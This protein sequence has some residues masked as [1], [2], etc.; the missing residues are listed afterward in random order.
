MARDWNKAVKTDQETFLLPKGKMLWPSIFEKSNIKGE[1]DPEKA[2][3]NLTVLLPKG[4]DLSVIQTAIEGVIDDNVSKAQREKMK[5]KKPWIKTVEQPKVVDILE[6]ANLKAEDFPI[7]VRLAAKIKPEIRAA[8]LSEVKDSELVYGG[9]WACVSVRPYW[10]K[11]DTGGVGVSLG[12][13]NVQ[14]LDDDEPLGGGRVSANAEFEAA[15]TEGGSSDSV[16]D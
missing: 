5:I 2:R 14:I 1:K 7:M 13:N 10:W 9:R 12:L 8:N 6:R 4:V 11:H 15:E 16:F 3:Y